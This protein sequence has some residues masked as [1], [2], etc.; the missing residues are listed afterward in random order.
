MSQASSFWQQLIQQLPEFKTGSSKQQP[1]K[2]WYEPGHFLGLLTVIVAMLFWNWKLLL[3]LFIGIV[4]MLFAYSI[5]K[6]NLEISW[7][8]IRQFL[9]SPKIRLSLAVFSGG[10]ATFMTY[11][12]IAICQNSPNIWIATGAILQGLGT[13]LTL[14]FLVWQI[15]NFQESQAENNLQQLLNKLTETDSLKRL[16]AVRQINQFIIRKNFDNSA[17]QDVMNCL[18]IL[19]VQEE[20]TVIREAVLNSLQSLDIPNNLVPNYNQPLAPIPKKVKQEVY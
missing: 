8:E 16:L 1:L 17:K 10:I 13:I 4:V 11:I 12:A 2:R 5:P 14:I 18:K 9:N 3:A 6:W 20:E 15:L 7:S 19:L